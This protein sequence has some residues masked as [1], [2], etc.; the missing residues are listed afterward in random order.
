MT[1]IDQHPSIFGLAVFLLFFVLAASALRRGKAELPLHI[2]SF[3]VSRAEKPYHY[4]F[5]VTLY[6]LIALKFLYTAWTGII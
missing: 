5:A 1:Y 3:T 4:W 2:W 6:V